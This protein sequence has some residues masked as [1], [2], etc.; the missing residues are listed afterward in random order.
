MLV[1]LALRHEALVAGE[2]AE[3]ASTAEQDVGAAGFGEEQE[4]GDEDGSRGPDGDEEG[5]SPAFDGDGETTEER[6][7]GS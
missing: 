4:H 2:L 6:T 1:N 7:K 3:A 5:P